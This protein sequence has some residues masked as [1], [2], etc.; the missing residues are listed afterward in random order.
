M[1]VIRRV[2]RGWVYC[3]TPYPSLIRVG[4]ECFLNL[5]YNSASLCHSLG[6]TL[7]AQYP[8]SPASPTSPRSPYSPT[9]PSRTLPRNFKS[10][11]EASGVHAL[12]EQ[13]S[14]YSISGSQTLPKNYKAVSPTTSPVG[15]PTKS[16]ERA[17][18]L[19]VS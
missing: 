17:M 3:S 14:R 2:G 4:M 16:L 6:A 7:P 12:L 13:P 18:D 15:S 19:P 8:G 10:Y 5:T 11:H 1:Q 9:S